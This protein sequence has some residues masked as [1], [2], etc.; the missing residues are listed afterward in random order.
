MID[1][2]SLI[3]QAHS[4]FNIQEYDKA[5]FL[6]SQVF[7]TEPSSKEYQLYCIFCD[8]GF[9]SDE[10]A[11]TLFDYF[12]VAK[13][14]NFDEAVAYVEDVINA[15]DG[16]N[17][18]MM[19]LLQDISNTNVETLNAIEY[20]D[21][22]QLVENRGSFKEAYQDIMFSTKVAIT[23][24]DDLL[25]FIDK[26]IENNFNKTAYSYLDGF[27]EFFSYDEDLTKL[28]E[29]LGKKTLAAKTE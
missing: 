24:K 18:K 21:F 12:I 3:K 11:Q 10:K 25:D 7:S 6:Y 27:N 2:D 17:S 19:N 13:D 28:Y 15:Y 8:L 1:I 26:L 4:Y 29:R 23:S 22:M 16:D 14:E 9:E 5:L 20:K